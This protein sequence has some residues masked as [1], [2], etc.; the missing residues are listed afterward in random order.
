MTSDQKINPSVGAVVFK[1]SDV[2]LIKRGKAPLKGHWSIPGGK[3]EF[4]EPLEQALIREV[5]EETGVEIKILGL[6][7]VFES[8]P[9]S[10]INKHYLMVDYV[11]EWVSGEVAAGD[12]ADEAEFVSFPEALSRLAWDQTRRALQQAR[13]ARQRALEA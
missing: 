11:A 3:V 13:K 2:L 6:I 9:T 1:G 10:T 4:G 7:D 8:L 5:R 12:D